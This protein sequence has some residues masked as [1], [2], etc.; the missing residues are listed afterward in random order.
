MHIGRAYRTAMAWQAAA[1]VAVAVVAAVTA[2]G[3]GLLSALFGG[4]IGV[5]GVLVFALI[6]SRRQASAGNVVRVLIRAEA[7]KII[8]IVLLLWLA[9]AAYR[10]MVVLAFMAAFIVSVLLSGIAHAVSDD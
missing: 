8:A 2:G 9:F 10:D 5:I 3:Q 1:S 7:A 4:G 6:A